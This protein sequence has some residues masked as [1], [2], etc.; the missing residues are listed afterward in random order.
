MSFRSMLDRRVTVLR[1]VAVKDDQGVVNANP[2]EQAV[3]I[4]PCSATVASSTMTQGTPQAK[5]S[6]VYSL[7]FLLT[8]DIRAGDLATIPGIGKLRLGKPHDVR[9]H[10]LE[11]S[12][13]WE[14]D[15]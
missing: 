8:A 12:G 1:M 7:C 9:G 13:A 10:H 5:Q 2:N 11:V 14:G 15:V 3:G 6:E 4:Y